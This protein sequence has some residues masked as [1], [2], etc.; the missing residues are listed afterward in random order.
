MTAK[1]DDAIGAVQT[2]LA[3][4]SKT[5]ADTLYYLKEMKTLDEA[6]VSEA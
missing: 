2:H 5:L 3:A 1:G 6:H 4:H